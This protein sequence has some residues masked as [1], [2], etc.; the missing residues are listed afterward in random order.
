[1][2]NILELNL[3]EHGHKLNEDVKPVMLRLF[4]EKSEFCKRNYLPY[5]NGRLARN[6]AG[7]LHAQ[8]AVA[9]MENPAIGTSIM[10]AD[11]D[12]QTLLNLD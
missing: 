4:A 11:I 12:Y 8:H 7:E 9:Y 10:L 6:I 1:M 3:N 2:L 5:A